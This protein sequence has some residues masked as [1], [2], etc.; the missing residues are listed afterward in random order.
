MLATGIVPTEANVA[1]RTMNPLPVRPA[2]PFE[3]SN[4]TPMMP[5]WC[6]KVRSVLVAC[7][8]NRAAIVR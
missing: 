8:R 6:V 4:K 3:V 2:A 1:A 5:S 7:A